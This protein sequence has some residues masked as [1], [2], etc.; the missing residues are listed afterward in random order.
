MSEFPETIIFTGFRATGKTSVGR[1]LAARLNYAFVDADSVLCDRL[2]G[3]VAE[4]VARSGWESFRQAERELLLETQTMT[5]TVIATGGGAIEQTAEWDLLREWSFVVWLEADEATIRRRMAGDAQTAAQRP[6]LTGDAPQDEIATLLARRSPLYAAGSDV[7]LD[8]V[9]RTPEQLAGK[10]AALVTT[11]QAGHPE[12]RPVAH[13]PSETRGAKKERTMSEDINSD[14]RLVWLV[15]RE[16]EGL[17]GAGGVKDVCRQLAE[18]LVARAGCTVRVVLPRYGF[19]D[20]AHLGFTPVDLGNRHGRI[21]ARRFNHVFEV[22]MNYAAEERREQVAVWQRMMNGVQVFLVEADRFAAKRGVYTYTEIDEQ[23]VAWQRAG[24]GHFDYFAMN[25]LLQKVALDLMILL[26]ERPDVIHCHDGHAAT[27]P[28]MMRENAGWRAYFRRTGAVVT[29]HNAGLGYHQ[30][31]D[32]IEFARA[33]TSLP[34]RVILSSRLGGS[35]DPFLAA[36]PYAALNTVSENYGRELQETPDD[37]RTGWLGHALLDRGVHLAGIT[38]GIDP[39]SF[40]P[41]RPE[42]L[43]L[44]AAF[45]VR[46]G[47]LAGKKI[48]KETLLQRVSTNVPWERVKQFGSLPAEADSPLL[49]FIGRLTQ[50]KGVDILIQ[51]IDDLLLLEP[52]ARFLV[53]GSGAP[54]LE[55]QLELLTASEIGRNRVCFL[56]GFDPLLANSIYAAGDFFLIPSRY[57]PCGLT[58]YIAQLLGN[59]PIVHRVGGLVKVIDG[60]TGF[61]YADNTPEALTQAMGRA[62]TTYLEDPWALR[63]MQVAAVERIA[64]LH[65]WEKVM[66]DYLL[67][68]RQARRMY[69]GGR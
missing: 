38:N 6:S 22:D 13:R 45:D 65:T 17:A 32:D 30:E 31:T 3:T 33:V 25:V 40:D 28:A 23:E 4:I 57:E 61:A 69:A 20:A 21:A 58:D 50:Q 14:I 39:A 9:D 1:R 53:F 11:K 66:D 29:V 15:T 26:E 35:F 18:S 64:R 16:Y 27:L 55:Q 47:E 36:S 19:V 67:L 46:R 52:L 8:T 37:A 43:G 41:S 24:G 68:Y 54:E 34:E 62:L 60:E 44:A 10:L 56:R 5:R 51:A 63:T 12:D 48:C 2:G 7:R 49:T 42:Q 59:L